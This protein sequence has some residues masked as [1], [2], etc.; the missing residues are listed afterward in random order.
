[1]N[2]TYL[3]L[4]LHISPFGLPRWNETWSQASTAPASPRGPWP[5][6]ATV[7]M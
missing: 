2:D 6:A 1:M 7:A 3:Y 5:T 4:P